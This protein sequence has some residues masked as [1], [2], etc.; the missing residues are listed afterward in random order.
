MVTP[1]P[2]APPAYDETYTY[3][4]IGNLTS[5][6]GVGAYTYGPTNSGPHQARTVG[7]ATSS[8]DA[9]GNLTSGGGR[10]FTWMRAGFA[11]RAPHWGRSAP[12]DPL[13]MML[14]AQSRH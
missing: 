3:D 6:S 10:T 9:N 1:V 12:P 11:P 14:V 13:Q 5:K 2:S 8:Y 7:G 4:T